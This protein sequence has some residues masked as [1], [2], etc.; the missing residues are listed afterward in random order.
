MGWKDRWQL[1]VHLNRTHLSL[2]F[3]LESVNIELDGW[4]AIAQFFEIKQHTHTHLVVQQEEVLE[5]PPLM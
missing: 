1:E 5:T 2:L 4:N 3:Y